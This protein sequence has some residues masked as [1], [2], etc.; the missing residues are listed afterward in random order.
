MPDSS[1]EVFF[2]PH[3]TAGLLMKVSCN[4]HSHVVGG[5]D[6]V[7]AD[8]SAS[9]PIDDLLFSHWLDDRQPTHNMHASLLIKQEVQGK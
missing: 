5:G 3:V 2:L 7:E 4:L 9:V 1:D 8:R 6:C